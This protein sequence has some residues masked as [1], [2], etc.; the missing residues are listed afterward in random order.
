MG[1]GCV[2][3]AAPAD[4]TRWL[5]PTWRRDITREI[6]LVEEIARIQGYDSVP[7][8]HAISVRPVE[9]SARER[10]LRTATAVLVSAGMC[11]AM[12]RSVVSEALEAT[13]SP[14]STAACLVVSPA[15]VRGAD[16]LRRTL[17][18]SLL[19]ARGDNMAVGAP[20]GDLFE[21]AH[22]YLARVAGGPAGHE[23]SP[24][25]EPLLLALVTG[26]DFS[27]AKGRAEAVLR[28]LRVG[29]NQSGPAASSILYRPVA[30]D[31]FASG[32]GAEIVL[33]RPD[34]EPERV[35]VVGEF[36]PA[37]LQR[38]D[39]V[40]PVSGAEIRL[41]RL[42]FA[43]AVEPKVQRPSDYQAV[44]RDLNLVVDQAVPWGEIASA[45]RDAAGELLED[46]RLVQ[47][48][49]DAERLGAGRKSF[50]VALRLRSTTGTLSSDATRGVVEQI[51]AACG[52]RCGAAL[53]G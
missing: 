34:R 32:R 15:L 17:L 1:L 21:V 27:A 33:H 38:F 42:E 29:W 9:P 28:R 44:Q 20:H 37:A 25:E 6:D 24:A 41:D 35:G 36:A 22:A 16:R 50:V 8:G 12:T 13:A 10:T 4:R 23:H 45:V 53:R 49:E 7:E 19:E 30:L 18:P 47:V 40:G 46:C 43:V 5:A 14:W 11:E 3:E 2:A 31:I 26:G 52:A 51:V 48:W 39:L